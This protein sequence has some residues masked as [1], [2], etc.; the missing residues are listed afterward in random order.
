M[1]SFQGKLLIASPHLPDPNFFRS[2]VLI[3][4]H[5]EQG[6]FGLVLNR[7][8]Q[9]TVAQIWEKVSEQPCENQE[10]IRMG[11]PI[12]GPLMAIHSEADCSENEILPHVFFAAHKDNL[13]RIVTG[14]Q[15]PFR[16][17]SGYSGWGVGQLE[18]EL[19]VGGWLTTPATSRHIFHKPEEELW[20][21]VTRTIGDDILR[22]SLSLKQIPDDPSMN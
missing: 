10:P 1:K 17:F 4:Q 20:E 13:D 22:S 3:I 6:A 7:P 8:T 21:N 18:S 19:K 11:G 12:E 9:S 2:V 5:N 14:S 16:L 15:Q